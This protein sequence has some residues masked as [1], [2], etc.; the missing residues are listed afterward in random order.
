MTREEFEKKKTEAVI[1]SLNQELSLN[2]TGKNRIANHK[3]RIT[4]LTTLKERIEKGEFWT[5]E[6]E[7][8]YNSLYSKMD[9]DYPVS[10]Y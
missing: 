3:R 2:P 7:Y 5:S 4:T 8:Y 10:A 6:L 9:S 1:N